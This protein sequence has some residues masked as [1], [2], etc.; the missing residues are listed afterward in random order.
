MFRAVKPNHKPMK[1]SDLPVNST[2]PLRIFVLTCRDEKIDYVRLLAS[3][4]QDRGVETYYIWLRRRPIVAGP[5]AAALPKGMSFLRF[6]MFLMSFDRRDAVNIYFNSTSTSFPWISLLIRLLAAPGVWCLDVYD[7][8]LYDTRGL[9]RLRTVAAIKV[10]QWGS[11]LLV[12]A[13]PTLSELFPKSHHLGNASH[14]R[15]AV[16]EKTDFDKVLIISNLDK[17]FDFEL[18]ESTARRCVGTDFHIYGQLIDSDVKT[19]LEQLRVHCKNVHYLG[20]YTTDEL[21]RLLER[22]AIT[23]APY[24]VHE[25]TRYI[26]PLRYYHCLNSG[27]ELVTTG[28]PQARNFNEALHIIKSADEFAEVLEKLR[29]DPMARRNTP[30]R[31]SLQTWEMR[32]NRLFEI[33]RGLPRREKLAKRVKNTKM[34]MVSG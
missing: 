4:L 26:D 5:T 27:M 17:R 23:F 32:V 19:Q 18:M 25:F 16:R 6:L 34:C 3:A 20:P 12:H 10:L 33:L 31:Y 2:A 8:F 28:I 15:P 9:R 21:P 30:Q 29:S 22:Y 7:N 14:I 24:R 1:Q 11:D 13:A